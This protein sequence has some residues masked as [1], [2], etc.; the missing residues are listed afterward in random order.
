[1]FT[2]SSCLPTFTLSVFS[3]KWSNLQPPALP[4]P[5]G[6]LSTSVTL[7]FHCPSWNHNARSMW[8]LGNTHL[9]YNTL[10]RF[11]AP[12]LGIHYT[13]TPNLKGA[14]KTPP[15]N[16]SFFPL[17]I[18]FE[19]LFSNLLFPL[20]IFILLFPFTFSFVHYTSSFTFLLPV[21]LPSVSLNLKYH[22]GKG[23]QVKGYD[24][25]NYCHA[26]MFLFSHSDK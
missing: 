12:K 5:R 24:R 18:C 6:F 4:A 17:P 21:F 9:F 19:S 11:G 15:G 3:V 26:V 7:C 2:H 13:R 10:V 16:L 25:H 23:S 14:P 22:S 1:M 8:T 20:S